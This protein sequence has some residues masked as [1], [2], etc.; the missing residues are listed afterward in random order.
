MREEGGVALIDF[1]PNRFQK[2]YQ[3]ILYTDKPVILWLLQ[4]CGTTITCALYGC[5]YTQSTP[6]CVC[7][8]EHSVAHTSLTIED[9][10]YSRGLSGDFIGGGGGGNM[11]DK[12]SKKGHNTLLCTV[13]VIC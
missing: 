9:I 11:V 10:L 5:M 7:C 2:L 3:F 13:G 6:V 1:F 4:V 8:T 12:D